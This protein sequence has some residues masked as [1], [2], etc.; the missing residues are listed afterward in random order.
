MKKVF[1]FIVLVSL[2]V[3]CKNSTQ[4]TQTTATISQDS[5]LFLNVDEFLANQAEYVDRQVVV[6]GMV[7]HICKHGGQ[8]LFLL[9]TDPEKYL[10]INTGTDI[11][12]FPVDLEGSNIEVSG[13]VAE[14]ELDAAAPDST[15]VEGGHEN[16][17]SGMEH[18]YHKNNFYVIVADSYKVKE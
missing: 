3:G 6:T 1:F 10:R 5:V 2:F 8:K 4:S 11:A 13:V 9:G 7:S 16:D 12:E 18:K 17:S 15:A 14:F